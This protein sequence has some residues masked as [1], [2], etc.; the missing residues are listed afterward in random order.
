MLAARLCLG[1]LL[2]LGCAS[3]YE[4]AATVEGDAIMAEGEHAVALERSVLVDPAKAKGPREDRA[5]PVEVPAVLTLEDA[6]RIATQ[7]N[8]DYKTQRDTFFLTAQT[9]GLTRRDF[10]E[11]VFT[12][13][14]SNNLV[15][16]EEIELF[17]STALAFTGTRTVLP[18]GGSLTVT[19][20]WTQFYEPDAMH[21]VTGTATFTQPL[22]RGAGKSVA[23]EP[24]TLAE[25]GLVYQARAFEIYRQDFT[26]SI[27][28]QYASLVSQRRGVKNAENRVAG[29]DYSQRQA[30]ALYRL[31]LGPQT[32]VFRAEREYLTAQNALLDA[33][34]GYQ[35]ALDQFKITL[36]LPLSAPFDLVDEI[37]LPPDLDPG[38]DAAV[39]AA[40]ANRL[41]LATTRQQTE[42][43]ARS[44]MV[45]RNALLP[46][47]DFTAAYNSIVAGNTLAEFGFE[48]DNWNVGLSLEIPLNRKPERNAYKAAL[49]TYEQS[50]R[51]LQ[52]TEDNAILSVR[53][54]LRRLQQTR[55][56]IQ[57][58][59]D[60]IRTIERLLLKAD[61]DNRAGRGSNRDVV[62]A[63][64]D[65]AVAKD[66]LNDRYVS[67]LIDT[68]NL[69]QEMG[70][71]FVGKNGQVLR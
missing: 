10:K 20:T 18:T 46:D 48:P 35:L 57:N 41:D 8:R 16:G 19:G 31:E 32:D 44:V 2:G 22:L 56:Q 58:D 29:A 27:I 30:R 37:P 42:D 66:S 5:P 67:Y 63:T 12:G 11:W 15:D 14:L 50:K 28:E 36:G 43:A 26:I 47:L 3:S 61:L 49:I 59:K 6:L 69:Q 51:S 33:Q 52:Q 34:Q 55:V 1:V 13:S 45:A 60:N 64:N 65:L 25:R 39:E 23:W 62:E 68:L 4:R 38:V 53:D 71:L 21:T 7:C 24:L 17:E 9:L 40:L 54:A 70:L